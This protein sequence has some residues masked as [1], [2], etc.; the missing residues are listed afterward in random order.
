ME[1]SSF[2]G[3][4][5]HSQGTKRPADDSQESQQ[6]K[7]PK[8]DPPTTTTTNSTSS[9]SSSG[10]PLVTLRALM[11]ERQAMG[12]PSH[13]RILGTHG[14]P[15]RMLLRKRRRCPRH[16]LHPP[17]SLLFL[18]LRGGGEATAVTTLQVLGD[19]VFK[20]LMK[21]TCEWNKV[22]LARQLTEG[23]FQGVD[24]EVR[25]KGGLAQYLSENG[26]EEREGELLGRGTIWDE[27][28]LRGRARGSWR[29]R[30]RRRSRRKVERGEQ[31]S[32]KWGAT[33][34]LSVKQEEEAY[35]LDNDNHRKGSRL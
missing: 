15:S 13:R 12:R 29:R 27:F 21:D 16:P 6:E 22:T 5:S 35:C 4:S 17:A 33:N 30:R 3:E 11:R 25:R 9:S 26:E 14:F 8:N 19:L 2:Q 20:S 28:V 18:Q 34:M 31:D 1:I 7:K 24:R 23:W 32:A 10:V